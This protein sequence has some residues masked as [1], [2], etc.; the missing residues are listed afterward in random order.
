[1]VAKGASVRLS[2]FGLMAG[3]ATSPLIAKPMQIT[4]GKEAYIH[5]GT[6]ILPMNAAAH[7]ALEGL[8][9]PD[10]IGSYIVYTCDVQSYQM[11]TMARTPLQPA[12]VAVSLLAVYEVKACEKVSELRPPSAN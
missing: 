1:M 7:S 2:I 12:A 9:K 6:T 3:L 4:V 8:Q 11:T 10:K 5:L